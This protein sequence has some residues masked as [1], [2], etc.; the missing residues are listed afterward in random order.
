MLQENFSGILVVKAM[1]MTTNPPM[2]AGTSR[3]SRALLPPAKLSDLEQG[4]RVT[5]RLTRS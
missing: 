4:L 1:V 3:N 2:K 5:V